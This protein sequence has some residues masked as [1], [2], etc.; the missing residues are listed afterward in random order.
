M[1]VLKGNRNN[2]LG[3]FEGLIEESTSAIAD[4]A[5]SNHPDSIALQRYLRYGHAS[6]GMP[7]FETI[8]EFSDWMDG[9]DG[10]S[11][12]SVSIHIFSCSACREK[13]DLLRAAMFEEEARPRSSAS[14]WESLLNWRQPALRPVVSMLGLVVVVV[15]LVVFFNGLSPKQSVSGGDSDIGRVALSIGGSIHQVASF[16]K[17]PSP[18]KIS[19]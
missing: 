9:S 4:I 5:H 3:Y 11:A 15:G 14:L 1:D 6:E 7:R 12:S 10:W 8:E 17:A 19:F 16:E 2:E 18:G 13:V